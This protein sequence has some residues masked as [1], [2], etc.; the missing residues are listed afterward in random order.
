VKSAPCLSTLAQFK[1]SLGAVPHA[2]L[3]CSLLVLQ[4]GVPAASAAILAPAEAMAPRPAW[5]PKIK[6]GPKPGP[7]PERRPKPPSPPCYLHPRACRGG[8]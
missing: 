8:F 6:P 5:S 1:L 3:A 7:G 4:A 2:L